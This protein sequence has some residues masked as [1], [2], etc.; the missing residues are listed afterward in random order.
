MSTVV[1]GDSNIARFCKFMW[2]SDHD[3]KY[4]GIP[5]LRA[6]FLGKN[7][8]QQVAGFEKAEI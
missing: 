1:L 3:I 8:L 6:L 2:A 7:Q 5:G 4:L